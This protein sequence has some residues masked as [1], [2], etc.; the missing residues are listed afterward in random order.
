[1]LLTYGQTS[2]TVR[3]HLCKLSTNPDINIGIAFEDAGWDIYSAVSSFYTLP[4]LHHGAHLY[5]RWL[6]L[7]LAQSSIVCLL[8]RRYH[9]KGAA[10]NGVVL[11]CSV[12][13]DTSSPPTGGHICPR[14]IP[15]TRGH[16]CNPYLFWSQYSGF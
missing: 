15:Q 14:P 4:V 16:V 7:S 10:S 3:E 13:T 5:L 6:G 12:L 11:E 1:M 2:I 9:H 8:G